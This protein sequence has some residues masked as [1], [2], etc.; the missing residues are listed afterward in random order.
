MKNYDIIKLWNFKF[1][2]F[3]LIFLQTF[4]FSGCWSSKIE[5]SKLVVINVLDATYYDDCHMTGSIN[6]PFENL[7]NRMKSLNKNNSYVFYC[8]NY[9]CTAAPYAAGMFKEAGFKNVS[10]FTGGIV[11]WFKAGCPVTG[12]AQKEYLNEENEPLSDEDHKDIMVISLEDL[13]AQMASANM[14]E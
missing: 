13:K 1:L 4:F 7:E 9:A 12:P 2:F 10:V 5:S 14:F 11:E 6:I 3:S 8:S